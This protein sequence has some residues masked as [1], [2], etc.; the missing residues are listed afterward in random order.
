MSEPIYLVCSGCR[1]GES[2]C[3]CSAFGA[4]YHFSSPP[5]CRCGRPLV[6]GHPRGAVAVRTEARPDVDACGS[7]QRC[8]VLG[9][10]F[11]NDD[12]GALLSHVLDVHGAAADGDLA[13]PVVP[14]LVPPPLLCNACEERDADCERKP[15]RWYAVPLN[16]EHLQALVLVALHPVC[17]ERAGVGE[18]L[19][20]VAVGLVSGCLRGEGVPVVGFNAEG[21]NV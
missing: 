12:V 7:L 17:A 9:C 14:A 8:D 10:G 18:A 4:G 21:G 16:H 5:W 1:L 13:R 6:K 19:T 20:R 15:L 3:T 2:A 11:E